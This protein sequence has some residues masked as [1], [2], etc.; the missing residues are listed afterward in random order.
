MFD[1]QCLQRWV[2]EAMNQLPSAILHLVSG[3]SVEELEL[4]TLAVVPK[5]FVVN[6]FSDFSCLPSTVIYMTEKGTQ[7]IDAF[8]KINDNSIVLIQTS[9]QATNNTGK[10]KSIVGT[11]LFIRNMFK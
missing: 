6:S 8:V 2:H 9:I 7:A 5:R 11:P 1:G 10:V 3:A 4:P